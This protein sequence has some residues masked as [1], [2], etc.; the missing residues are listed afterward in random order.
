MSD[1]DIARKPTRREQVVARAL[2]ALVFCVVTVLLVAALINI[3]RNPGVKSVIV[4]I[5][6][7]ALWLI[8][9][10]VCYRSFF[11]QRQPPSNKAVIF[12]G[13]I[14]G[15]LGVLLKLASAVSSESNFYLASV[16]LTA[17]CGAIT[18]VRNKNE[19]KG[20]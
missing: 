19:W 10:V 12:V 5:L 9:G 7:L 13:Y 15:V 6:P 8:S 11:T 16:G 4:S 2:S 17:V 20:S 18:I 1:W 14:I 3:F